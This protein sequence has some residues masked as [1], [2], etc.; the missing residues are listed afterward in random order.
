VARDSM[1]ADMCSEFP[2]YGLDRHGGYGTKEHIEAIKLLGP[3]PEHR[4]SFAPIK[5]KR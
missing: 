5:L 1:V 4:W 3:S 2:G